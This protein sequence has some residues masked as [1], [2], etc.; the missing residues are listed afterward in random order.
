MPVVH[1]QCPSTNP[2][3]NSQ[4]SYHRL[5]NSRRLQHIIRR[6]L[7]TSRH[8]IPPNLL[9]YALRLL[10]N[11]PVGTC[12]RSQPL[13]VVHFLPLV[14]HLA[15]CILEVHFR[16]RR[17]PHPRAVLNNRATRGV[18]VHIASLA[19]VHS[20]LSARDD[21]DRVGDVCQVRGAAH[22]AADDQGLVD[23]LEGK[24]CE[25]LAEGSRRRHVYHAA[26]KVG[27]GAG[28]CG[29]GG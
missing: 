14:R 21:D 6:I 16:E 11:S 28:A 15:I 22:V 1:H 9:R 12:L 8:H 7:R 25:G 4:N 29:V 27:E 20:E 17:E 10:Q 5:K 19:L 13:E 3:P 26:V 2:S 24:S 23:V 18:Q